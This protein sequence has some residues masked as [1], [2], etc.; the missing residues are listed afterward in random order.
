MK[1]RI[2]SVLLISM[3]LFAGCEKA[4]PQ[5]RDN[6]RPTPTIIPNPYV[7][8]EEA[9]AEMSAKE[10]PVTKGGSPWLDTNLKENLT[11]DLERSPK[12]DFYLYAN[13]DWLMNTEIP[14][15]FSFYNESVMMAEKIAREFEELLK[16]ES[17]QGRD[18]DLLRDVYR[19]T[20]DWDARNARGVEPMMKTVERIR[21]IKS[22][23]ELQDFLCDPEKD[24]RVPVFVRLKNIELTDGTYYFFIYP[25]E[26][27]LEEPEEYDLDAISDVGLRKWEASE[28]YVKGLLSRVGYDEEEA[29]RAFSWAIATEAYLAEG[30]SEGK[31]AILYDQPGEK[32]AYYDFRFP[33][34]NLVDAYG[35][36]EARECAC[37]NLRYMENLEKLMNPMALGYVKAYLTVKFVM[38]AGKD[39]DR[40]S[41]DLRTRYLN[42]KNGSIGGASDETWT[43]IL[44][45]DTPLNELMVR[46][47][48]LKYD[49]TPEKE[50]V[51]ALSRQIIKEYRE[52]ILEEDWISEKVKTKAV[53]KLDNVSVEVGYPERLRSYDDLD[54]KGLDYWELGKVIQEISHAEDVAHT[55]GVMERIEWELSMLEKNGYYTNA[56]NA[57][58]IPMGVLLDCKYHDNMSVEEFYARVGTV[59]GHEISHAYGPKG[60]LNDKDGN[61][62]WPEEE[63]Q[64]FEERM[65]KLRDSLKDAVI[66]EGNPVSADKICEE[67]CADITGLKVILRLARK[68]E[69]FD[70]DKFFKAYAENWRSLCSYEVEEYDNLRSKHPSAFFRVN[71]VLRQFDEFMETYDV[72]EGDRMYLAPED[73]AWVW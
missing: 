67:I 13:Y 61:A 8:S 51:E 41:S 40:E 25:D 14:N 28:D 47:Y 34:M 30:M 59:I 1:Q 27:I 16:D 6:D 63:K 26:F 10:P 62:W 72:Q 49:L 55:N 12:D 65:A 32:E 38:N 33:L 45:M 21:G 54:V 36:G 50:Q 56:G 2:L 68:Q 60:I 48:L 24:Y 35:Y 64:V 57:V 11:E 7:E 15:G 66:W 3:L 44:Y 18:A 20:L 4:L 19:I 39:L 5:V 70:Y 42:Q 46:A 58:Q 73:R 53:E 71:F 37:E 31:V 43:Y 17:I 52:M 9:L 23:E 69:A 22:I 29:E